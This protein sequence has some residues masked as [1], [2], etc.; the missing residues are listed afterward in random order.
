MKAQVFL[1]M[2]SSGQEYLG[3]SKISQGKEKISLNHNI[4]PWMGEEEYLKRMKEFNISEVEVISSKDK[5][6]KRAS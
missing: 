6:L 2:G 4:E 3:V 5:N 1:I